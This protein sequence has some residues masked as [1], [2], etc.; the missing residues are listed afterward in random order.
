MHDAK[1]NLSRYVDELAPGDTLV[2]C[3]RNEPVAEIRKLDK[4]KKRVPRI[5]VA[6]GE[7][8]LPDSFFDPLPEEIMRSFRGE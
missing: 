2:L 1:T 5:G 6:E 3:S 4:K 8:E 7:F